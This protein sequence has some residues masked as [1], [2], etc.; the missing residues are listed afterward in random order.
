M[1]E[2]TDEYDDVMDE[3]RETTVF[4]LDA[5]NGTLSAPQTHQTTFPGDEAAA[6]GSARHVADLAR[7]RNDVDVELEYLG[8]AEDYPL[9]GQYHEFRFTV[10][11]A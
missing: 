5:T 1:S 11:E 4:V 8:V 3:F 9:D 10:S 2:T 7:E 6:R